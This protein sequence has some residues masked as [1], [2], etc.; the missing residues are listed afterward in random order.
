[1]IATSQAV[2][3]PKSLHFSISITSYGRYSSN[4]ADESSA[5]RYNPR[6]AP[7]VE[8]GGFEAGRVKEDKVDET[9]SFAAN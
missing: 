7:P 9:S 5:E 8:F 4:R 1:M 2:S 6:P 3:F